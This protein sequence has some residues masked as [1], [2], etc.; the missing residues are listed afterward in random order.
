MDVFALRDRVIADYA[1]YVRSFVTISDPQI[2]AFVAGELA[3]G[4]WWPEP[5]V[6][7]NPAFESAGT[8][9]DLVDAG[10][11]HPECA[12]IFRRGKAPEHGVPG[13]SI[14]LHHHQRVA[15]ACAH[16]GQSYVLTTGTGSGKSLTYVLPIVDHVLRQRDRGARRGIAALVIYPMNALVNSQ[17]NELQRYLTV[18]YG[19]GHEPVRFARYTG[20]ESTDEKDRIAADPPDILLTNYMMAELLL[21]RGDRNDRRLLAAAQG[22]EFLVLDE[23]HTYRGRQGADI[24]LL[25][26]RIRA[27]IGSATM[28]CIGT[29]ATIAGRG[30]RE[31]RH[32]AA[33][34]LASRLCG[35]TITTDAV[36]GETLRRVA[37]G[38]PASGAALRAA[39][40][41][42]ADY[43][44]LD[45][46]AL[47]HHPLTEWIERAFGLQQDAAGRLERRAPQTLPAAAEQLAQLSGADVAQCRAHLAALL[48]AGY[49]VGHPDTG[50]PLVAFRLHQFISRGDTVFAGLAAAD[51][52]RYLTVEGQQYVPGTSD[53]RH[54]LLPLA[55]CRDCGHE[56]YVVTLDRRAGV[57]RARRLQDGDDGLGQAGV[58]TAYRAERDG[59]IEQHF[60]DDWL[61][62]RRDGT[63]RTRPVLRE[64]LPQRIRIAVDGRIDE[65]G[66]D[67]WFV[68]TP[69]RLCLQCH[70][71]HDG[72]GSEF[73]R[74][75][76]LASTGRSTATTILALATVRQLRAMPADALPRGARK[77]LSFSD[78][79]Q[80][81]SLQA[82][83]LN[84]FVQVALL[85]G[86]LTAALQHAGDAGI[87]HDRIAAAVTRALGLE[88]AEYASN[89]DAI[90]LARRSAEEALEGVTGYRLYLDLRRGWRIN[91]PN[92]EQTGLL[93]IEYPWL[94]E[95][96]AEPTL[97][98]SG[99][100]LLR[101]ATPAHRAAAARL[102]LD[103]FRRSLAI[104]VLALDDQEQQRLRARS[105]QHLVEPWALAD[106]ERLQP[107]R[108]IGVALKPRAAAGLERSLGP[109]SQLGRWLRSAAC[110]GHGDGLLPEAQ[111]ADLAGELLAAL[112]RGGYLEVVGRSAGQPLYQLQAA[113]LRW[114]AGTGR[115][116][117][118]ARPDRRG[119]GAARRANHYFVQLYQAVALALRG[120]QAHEHTAQVPAARREAR[121]QAFREG[122]LPVLFCSP[123]MELGVDIA[124]LNVVHLRNVPP[125]PA[126]YAQ[127]SGRAGR[128]GQPALVLTYCSAPNA[129]DQY[130]FRR[131]ELMVAGAVTPPRIE[132]ANEDLVRAHV[133]A[134]WLAA[135]GHWLG[136]TIKELIDLE[137]AAAPRPL[138]LREPVRAALASPAARDDALHHCRRLLAGLQAELRDA[139]WYRPDW[140]HATIDDAPRAFDAAFERWRQ[141]Y[142]A[143]ATQRELQHRIAG[144]HASG[145]EAVQRARTLRA[146]AEA[147]LHLLIADQ[148]GVTSDFYP[149]RYLASEGFLP[150]YNFP[151]LPL[152]A[153][154]PGRRVR[155]GRDGRDE[156]VARARFLAIAEFGP[157]NSIYYEGNRYRIARVLLTA[158]D[159]AEREPL[160]AAKLC[161]ACGY[162]HL[163]AARDAE[164]CAGCGTV[165]R[166]ATERFRTNLFRMQ[167]V[168]TVRADRITCDEEERQRQGYELL[169]AYAFAPRAGG[170]DIER[171][172]IEAADGGEL[173]QAVY[174]PAATI[175]RLN[176]G[177]RRRAAQAVEGFV[178]DYETGNWV[179]DA[180]DGTEAASRH[181]LQRVVPFV[182]DTRNALLLTLAA[183]E[184]ARLPTLSVALQRGIEAAF[185][186]EERELSVELLPS[187][188]APAHVLLYEAAEGGAGVLTRL[189]SEP[190]ALAR[191]AYAALAELHFAA[192][193]RDLQHAPHA[194]E[195]CVA[196]CYDCLLSYQ[197]QSLHRQLDRHL[198]RDVL[199]Q[200]ATGRARPLGRAHS[201]EQL[202]DQ[203]LAACDSELERRFV[204]FLYRHGYRLP[205]QA[206]LRLEPYGTRPDFVYLG[207][208]A[209]VYVDGPLHD[210]PARAARDREIVARLAADWDVIRVRHDDEWPAVVA[211]WRDVFG[212]GD[213]HR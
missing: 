103:W 208:T 116:G 20:Q 121:E 179:S 22:L 95:W 73:G 180:D 204:R 43:T 65:R 77:V 132:L 27:R 181:A 162:G 1:E 146:E 141:L 115:P 171:V 88:F 26:R 89:R 190:D 175:Y 24:A 105:F 44:A 79:R 191:V 19:V 66:I 72:R 38:Q 198:A 45:G 210:E 120:V 18:G 67:L 202:R 118:D 12:R 206:Q 156:F 135:T 119:A 2:H 11:L 129:H 186:L 114:C 195:V 122:A 138:P 48:L 16:A 59:D 152:T 71:S 192:D 10:E 54:V 15:L 53:P 150:G 56:Y 37:H 47:L 50:A 177:W 147:Q 34:Q 3:A 96:A 174:A 51:A 6:Q 125:S 30:T 203:L 60:P 42:P 102:V 164:R 21:T 70:T 13:S 172:H 94:D 41:R 137:Q 182:Q 40:E 201:R 173:A 213:Q 145:P 117:A 139:A 189:A 123:T 55:F 49:H 39:L 23:L 128:N 25:V 85:R 178:L 131:P 113:A 136:R 33:A 64:Q 97:W 170:V 81:A 126:N 31:Q 154:I 167:N 61:E 9:E 32:A 158:G 161:A 193:G 196:A 74:L 165:L 91:A 28:R 163:G 92:L 197:N 62:A 5:L 200:L 159:G 168:A 205:D 63:R 151:R 68:P 69:F 207:A 14:R 107:A 90:L 57:C 134:T 106:D 86:A 109:R 7:L 84:D 52:P 185:Q 209:A 29:S 98:A 112:A 110:W 140:L 169:T 187:A 153:F 199:L 155:D 194:R 160:Q 188:D 148:P 133:H 99:H 176:L 93:R 130:F 183:T 82:G 144:D 184:A 142:L 36:I 87:E 211:E 143:A 46:A 8:V 35:T 17:L 108:M 76:E 75:C 149:Y 166:G 58:L 83:H 124:D 80:D 101:H 212:P 111:F 4:R 78:N 100:A 127:R 104:K 157:G